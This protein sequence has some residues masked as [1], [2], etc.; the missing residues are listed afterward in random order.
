MEIFRKMFAEKILKFHEGTNK[1]IKLMMKMPVIGAHIT[2][3]IFSVRKSGFRTFLG[4]VAQIVVL[5]YEFLLKLIYFATFIYVPYLYIS[6]KCP[7]VAL[8]KEQ[9][10]I[11]LFVIL[12]TICGSIVNNTAFS[13]A[14]RD[15]IM[16][17]VM[18]ISPY[19]NYLGR[20]IY[21]MAEDFV[22][23]TI[24]LRIFDVSVVNAIM[25]SVVTVSARPIGEMLAIIGYEHMSV[26]YSNRNAF[27][28]IFMAAGVIIAY[29]FPMLT[30]RIAGFWMLFVNP[31]FMIFMIAVG[32]LSMLYIWK[33][34]HYRELMRTSLHRQRNE[35]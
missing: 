12:S 4:I 15:Y 35:G 9:A 20:L 32:A 8:H 7:L 16:I 3:D 13:M 1:A 10:I 30:R 33:Y 11:Y 27:N 34:K 18:Q 19:M 5:V 25:L 6:L 31:V 21:K 26:I 17:K 29:G 23:F 28:G 2:D 24:I 14:Q 22:F